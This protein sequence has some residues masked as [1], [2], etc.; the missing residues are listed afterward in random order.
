[1]RESIPLKE[2]P[3]DIVLIV[4]FALNLLLVTYIISLEQIVIADP[5]SFAYPAWPPRFWVD[6]VH[7]YGARWDP[8]L[9]ARPAWY[10][11]TI[12]W[13]V[14]FFGPFY[15]LAIPS[16]LLAKEWIRIPSIAYASVMIALVSVILAEEI[17]GLHAAPNPTPVVA[18]NA[19]WILFPLVLL[20]RM[21]FSPHPFTRRFGAGRADKQAS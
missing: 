16:F 6:L 1:M 20:A 13:D 19:P 11:A 14:L 17:G 8:A 3:V 15:A 4:F 5:S 18:L 7:D 10:R 21:A 9:M 12:W 2:R